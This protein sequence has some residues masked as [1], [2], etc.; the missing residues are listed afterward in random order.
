MNEDAVHE[1]FLKAL[2]R[3]PNEA[4]VNL[5][6][7]RATCILP[8]ETLA[9]KSPDTKETSMLTKL[10]SHYKQCLETV[11]FAKQEIVY[12]LFRCVPTG[13]TYSSS[14]EGKAEGDCGSLVHALSSE[15]SWAE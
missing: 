3:E 13:H 14:L 6:S 5:D 9:T 10:P 8:L 15:D 2:K 7:F 12:F 11:L 4:T 1:D